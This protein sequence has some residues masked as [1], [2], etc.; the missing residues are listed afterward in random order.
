VK[1]LIVDD[2][3]AMRMIIGRTLKTLGFETTEAA[4]GREALDAIAA[5]KGPFEI[6]LVDW[7]MPV[8]DGF[9]FVCN[10]RANPANRDMRIMMVTT[11]TEHTQVLRALE[12]GA[13][14]YLMKPFPP[15]AIAEKL[16]ILGLK[17]A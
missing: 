1:A 10:A 8:M 11:E 2:S 6:A 14:E 7:N 9:E 12:A 17:V 4:N 16:V 5:G 3:R 13:S 15:E